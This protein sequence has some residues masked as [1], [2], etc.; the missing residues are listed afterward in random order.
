MYFV[1]IITNPAKTV[2][3][4][5]VTNS[6]KHRLIE[7]WQQRGNAKSF[8]GRYSC[9]YLIYYESYQFVQDAIWRENQMKKWRRIKKL[10][11][12]RKNNPDLKFL[13]DE[14]FGQWPP[15]DLSLY[16]RRHS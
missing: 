11:L 13:N 5:G 16:L 4:T 8:S 2:L 6:I 1:Y 15:N 7:H 14:L 10:H 12:I 3:Y 9:Y